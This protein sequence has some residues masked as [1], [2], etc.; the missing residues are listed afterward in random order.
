MPPGYG[1]TPPPHS[2]VVAPKVFHRVLSRWTM[3]V[4]LSGESVRPNQ[5]AREL[6]SCGYRLLV[7]LSRYMPTF[8]SQRRALG[9]VFNAA[10]R[11]GGAVSRGVVAFAAEGP[12]L[13]V[14]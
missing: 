10:A 8:A 6:P 5:T 7:G 11:R 3:L 1:C 13:A 4:D 9:G 12:R 14:S 2:G